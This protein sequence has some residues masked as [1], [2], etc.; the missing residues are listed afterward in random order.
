MFA[1][2]QAMQSANPMQQMQQMPQQQPVQEE[3]NSQDGASPQGPQLGVPSSENSAMTIVGES[4]SNKDL[5]SL[6][7]I[8]NIITSLKH[9]YD[10][11]KKDQIELLKQ[12]MSGATPGQ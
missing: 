9:Q 8:I 2:M 12:Q 4:I 3:L 10:A 7:K 5:E 1:Q 11:M 6:I